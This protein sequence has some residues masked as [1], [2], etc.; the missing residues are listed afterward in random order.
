MQPTP[1]ASTFSALLAL[2]LIASPA[3]FAG[4]EPP[5]TEPRS[6]KTPPASTP[7]AAPSEDPAP[8]EG[9]DGSGEVLRGREVKKDDLESSRPFAGGKREGG[10]RLQ[11]KPA[12]ELGS[13]VAAVEAFELP[14]ERKAELVAACAA[15]RER[16]ASWETSSAE[17]KKKI[18]ASRKREAPDAP[19]SEEFKKAMAE[20]DA[21]RPKVVELRQ[22]IYALLDEEEGARLKKAYDEELARRRAE[23]AREVEAD[24]KRK[25]EARDAAKQE[26]ANRE[27]GEKD[28]DGKDPNE[29]DP[30]E[31]G[32][33]G[34]AP[35][36]PVKRDGSEGHAKPGA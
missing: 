15:F 8:A 5:A 20:L 2:S 22:Q 24:R 36:A 16:L 32:G 1:F 10:P 33:A 34:S 4:A 25:A 13:F 3:A 21:S 35:E 31:M 29:K 19:P 17:R 11:T 30:D 18:Y 23:I 14:A 6:D 7:A 12:L 9:A 26:A 27:K 28:P